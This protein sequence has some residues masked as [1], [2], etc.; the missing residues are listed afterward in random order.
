MLVHILRIYKFKCVLS[1]G[2]HARETRLDGLLGHLGSAR[3][4]CLFKCWLRFRK[5]HPVPH[6]LLFASDWAGTVSFDSG[7]PEIYFYLFC[8]SLTAAL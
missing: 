3:E 1:C 7:V 6:T 2:A 8:R 4:L 5:Q